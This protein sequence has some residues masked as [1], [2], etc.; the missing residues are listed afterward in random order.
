MT[1]AE[2]KALAPLKNLSHRDLGETPVTDA[3]RK[4]LAPL[5]KLTHLGLVGTRV[6]KKGVA[7]FQKALPNCKIVRQ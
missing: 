1:D 3:G 2:L 5:Q 6:T 7:E 4:E